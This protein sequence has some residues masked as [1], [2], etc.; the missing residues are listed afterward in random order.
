M[1]DSSARWVV[2]AQVG[3]LC[4]WLRASMPGSTSRAKITALV[5][6]SSRTAWMSAGADSDGW[7][8]NEVTAGVVRVRH[9]V[10]ISA[11]LAAC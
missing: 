11:I 2:R 3:R 9:L 1:V 6:L 4:A 7:A 8:C 10:G 5:R